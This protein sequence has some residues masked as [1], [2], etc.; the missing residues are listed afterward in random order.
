MLD[1]F[2]GLVL[3]ASPWLFGFADTACFPHEVLGW[4]EIGAVLLK[5]RVA[6]EERKEGGTQRRPG[7]ESRELAR[8]PWRLKVGRTSR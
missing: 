8:R 6:V 5:R 7:V 2:S 1:L 4:L 3:A